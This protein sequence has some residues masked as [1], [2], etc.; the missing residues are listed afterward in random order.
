MRALSHGA[1]HYKEHYTWSQDATRWASMQP[2]E[3]GEDNTRDVCGAC[4]KEE[5]YMF[6]E[7]G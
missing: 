2:F 3:V 4:C 5:L 7:Q 6:L 1:S